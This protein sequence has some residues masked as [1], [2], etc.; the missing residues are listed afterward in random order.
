MV[1]YNGTNTDVYRLL[2]N[3]STLELV[4]TVSNFDAISLETDVYGNI[5]LSSGTNVIKLD[6]SNGFTVSELATSFTSVKKIQT[7]LGG[8]VFVLDQ[9]KLK[10][11]V[12]NSVVDINVS[13]PSSSNLI[14]SFAMDYASDKVYFIY[15]NEEFIAFSDN[16]PNIA[17]SDLK[18][19][20]E[21]KITGKSAIEDLQTVKAKDGANVYSVTT[22][23]T[24]F[25]FN[26]LTPSGEEYLLVCEIEEVR[27][28][29]SV[30]MLAV[31]G[32]NGIFLID[33]TQA[34][35]STVNYLDSTAKS[36]FVTTDVNGYYFPIITENGEYALSQTDACVR[37]TKGTEIKPLKTVSF[38]NNDFYYAEISVNDGKIKG[39]VPKAFTVEVLAEDFTWNDY[40]IEKVKQTEFFVDD[41]LT[42][43]N[44]L[45]PTLF[46]GEKVRVKSIKDGV[47]LVLVA[48]GNG[49]FIEGY[50]AETAIKNEPSIAIRNILIILAVSACVLGTTAY[51]VIRKKE[52]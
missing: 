34:I 36:A 9:N 41:K 17:L 48:D 30:K 8:G 50:I 24:E 38:L 20:D 4:K 52:F 31:A 42:T 37:I 26:G 22:S 47:C 25:N 14:K 1:A 15:E 33:K 21:F 29:A 35:V 6:K 49:N 40:R 2:E 46:D 39:Y 32:E 18:V 7:D 51:F 10:Y 13:S 27:T 19:I 3:G 44:Q 23:D 5:Y 11:V 43:Q 16:L 12:E 45:K 28:H